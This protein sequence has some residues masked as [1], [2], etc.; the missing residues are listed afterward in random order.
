MEN[1]EIFAKIKFLSFSW[2]PPSKIS[3]RPLWS[4]RIY[5]KQGI[6]FKSFRNP[7]NLGKMFWRFLH[8]DLDLE[9]M[10]I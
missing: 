7:I 4:L 10:V 1:Y 2:V 8:P 3:F 5:L 6:Q 9:K